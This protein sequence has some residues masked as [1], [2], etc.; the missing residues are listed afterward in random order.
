[1]KTENMERLKLSNIVNLRQELETY[2][3][4]ERLRLHGKGHHALSLETVLEL[5]VFI[6]F[7]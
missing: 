7:D 3:K 1:M 6:A 4:M 5:R 2:V